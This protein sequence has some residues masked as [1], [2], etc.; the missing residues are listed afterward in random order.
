M[1]VPGLLALAILS[2]CG[3]ETE[4]TELALAGDWA[5]TGS[6]QLGPETVSMTLTQSGTVLWGTAAIRPVD[7]SDGSCVSCHKSKIGSVGGSVNGTTIRLTMFFAAGAS[8]D[9]TPICSI[10]LDGQKGS[11][12]AST[13]TIPYT[14]SDPCE[15]SFNGTISMTRRP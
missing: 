9:P 4:P 7:A 13:I 14:G 1:S 3:G 11:V 15:G 12:T 8:G 5:G 2:S 6:D 10:T